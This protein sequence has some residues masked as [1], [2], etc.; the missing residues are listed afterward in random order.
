MKWIARI[1]LAAVAAVLAAGGVIS[2][3]L[4]RGMPQL[5][6]DLHVKGLSAPVH[7][8]RDASDV[9]HMKRATPWTLGAPW[10]LYTPKSAAGNWL[11]TAV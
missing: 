2:V 4:L 11:L 1:L 7:I 5:D 9:T 3:H 8:T 6:G 10:A